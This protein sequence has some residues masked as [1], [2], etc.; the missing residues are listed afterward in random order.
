MK[1]ITTYLIPLLAA[2]FFLILSGCADMGFQLPPKSYKQ[3]VLDDYYILLSEEEIAEI[4]SFQTDEEINNFID[5]LWKGMDPTPKTEENELKEEYLKRL[6]YANE[7]YP[8]K[9]GWGRSE[10]KRIYMINGA[11]EFIE[12]KNKVGNLYSLGDTQVQDAEIW[13]Y[14]NIADYPEFNSRIGEEYAG[15]KRFVFVDT[16][17]VGVFKL[18][19]SSEDFG[20]NDARPVRSTNPD[21]IYFK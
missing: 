19:S 21:D 15:M 17:G 20:D 8:D 9:T 1:K 5:E 4:E 12:Y 14:F 13:V 2:T 10:R 11:P 18:L 3:A 7:Y 16:R 6:A